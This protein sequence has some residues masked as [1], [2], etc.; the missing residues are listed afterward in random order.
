[1]DQIQRQSGVRQPIRRRSQFPQPAFGHEKQE[2]FP[3]P[4]GNR[5]VR[6]QARPH[7]IPH[8]KAARRKPLGPVGWP[9]L[10]DVAIA[11]L[12]WNRRRKQDEI[13]RPG[14][15]RN[16]TVR[17]FRRQMLGHFQANRQIE[18][19]LQIQ[20][21][22]QVS[23]TKFF[24]GN[25]QQLLVHPSAIDAQHVRHAPLLQDGQPRADAAPDV[26]RR[27]DRR[28]PRQDQI[29]DPAGRRNSLL[30]AIGIKIGFVSGHEASPFWAR[31]QT[32]TG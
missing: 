23:A 14:Q 8:G 21:P 9:L 2:V 7:P 1:M 13:G 15:F 28:Q 16:K 20:W 27:P 26:H 29:Q 18:S 32:T 10:V 31:A 5:D 17:A 30:V 25:F 6:P 11:A 4:I 19:P 22:G 24:H 12:E 3:I